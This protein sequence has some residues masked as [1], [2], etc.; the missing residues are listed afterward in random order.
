MAWLFFGQEFKLRSKEW[1]NIFCRKTLKRFEELRKKFS[2]ILDAFNDCLI[3]F[4]VFNIALD[5]PNKQVSKN[6]SFILLKRFEE[7]AGMLASCL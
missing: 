6:V 1:R 7:I 3:S 2:S 5:V 4:G